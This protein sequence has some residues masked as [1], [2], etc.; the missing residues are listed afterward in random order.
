MN[1]LLLESI[2]ENLPY[3]AKIDTTTTA[4]FVVSLK[5]ELFYGE[6]EKTRF[7][8]QRRFPKL[9]MSMWNCT[10]FSRF[11]TT[12]ILRDSRPSV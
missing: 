5:T 9:T 12:F 11:T 1:L 7:H 8:L 2:I 4:A 6:C 3:T 10:R